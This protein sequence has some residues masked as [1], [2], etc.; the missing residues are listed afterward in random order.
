M[1]LFREKEPM[2]LVQSFAQYKSQL[3][4]LLKTHG[5]TRGWETG[6]I[7]TPT[8][9]ATPGAGSAGAGTVAGAYPR[10]HGGN[11]PIR[12][13]GKTRATCKCTSDREQ[14]GRWWRCGA[15]ASGKCQGLRNSP[16]VSGRIRC[17][18]RHCSVSVS[19]TVCL[20]LCLSVSS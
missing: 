2:G 12:R 14:T 11:D 7:S 9:M 8:A 20:T 3:V 16:F 6:T 18:C 10:E 15:V 1:Y 5:G 19:L 13:A 17:T 4:V